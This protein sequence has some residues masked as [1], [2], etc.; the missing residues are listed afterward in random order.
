[1]DELIALLKFAIINEDKF[2]EHDPDLVKHKWIEAAKKAI[3]SAQISQLEQS[4][5]Y[6]SGNRTRTNTRKEFE[7]GNNLLL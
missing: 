1:M 6:V 4:V 3:E 5:G 7:Y 2:T